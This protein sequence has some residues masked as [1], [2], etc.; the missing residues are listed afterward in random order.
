MNT[1]LSRDFNFG[2]NNNFSECVAMWAGWNKFS[3]FFCEIPLTKSQFIVYTNSALS[4]GKQ[5]EEFVTLII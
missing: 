3:Q 5:C 2:K 4:D 1:C